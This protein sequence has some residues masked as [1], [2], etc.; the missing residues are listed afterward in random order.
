MGRPAPQTNCTAR[1]T[2]AASLEEALAGAAPGSLICVTGDM[3]AT[4]LEIRN[5]GTP[6]APIHIL[7]DGRTTVHG[8][9]VTA[10]DVIVEGVNAVNADAPG[11]SLTGNDITVINDSSISPRGGDGDALRFWGNNIKILHN[12]MRDTR[13]LNGAHADCMQTF[14][15]DSEHVASQ[16]VLID[17]NRCEQIDN[18]CLIVEGPNSSAGDGSGVGETSDITFSNNYCDAHASEAVFMDDVQNVT[19]TGNDIVGRQ[20]H[21]FAFQNQVVNAHVGNNTIGPDIRY[22]VGIDDSSMQGYQGPPP[23]GAP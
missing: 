22:E 12:T 21:A 17:N 23:G 6:Q 15:T 4:R 16:H 5:S 10:N 8:I 3:G 2:D 1:A 19:L 11:I 7:G 18:T 13:N 9:T 20:S 14:A